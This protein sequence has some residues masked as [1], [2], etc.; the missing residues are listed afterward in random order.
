MILYS[1]LTLDKHI[2]N[3]CKT[4]SFALRLIGS[5]RKYLNRSQAETLVHAFVTSRL[6]ASNYLLLGLPECQIKKLQSIQSTAARLVTLKKKRNHITPILMGLHW[7]PVLQRIKFKTLLLTYKYL[8]GLAP[9]YISE[10][11]VPLN[12]GSRQLR[13]SDQHLLYIPSSRTSSHGDRAFSVNAPKLW[14]ALPLFIKQAENVS[15]FKK[16][17]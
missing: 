2:A 15:T 11:L 6:N 1:H 14:N 7:L 4:S 12:H 10:L 16:L 8:H 9:P 17:L 5:I 3:V 13:S